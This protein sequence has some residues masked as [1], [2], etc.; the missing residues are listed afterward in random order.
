MMALAAM[1]DIYEIMAK[2]VA[3]SISGERRE[4]EDAFLRLEWF[5]VPMQ[6]VAVRPGPAGYRF[7]R[8]AGAIIANAR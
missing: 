5:M 3:P 7:H 8:Y 4:A 6:C 2:S 1:P